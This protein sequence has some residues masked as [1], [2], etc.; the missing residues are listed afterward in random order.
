MKIKELFDYVDAV[1]PNAF[2]DEVKLVWLNE[3]EGAVQVQ[4]MLLSPADVVEY[5]VD[6]MDS[7]LLVDAPHSKIY[8][9]YIQAMIDLGNGE[10]DKYANSMEL[11]NRFWNEYS[12]WYALFIDPASGESELRGYYLSA[13][14]I[15]V[16]HGYEGTEEEWARVLIEAAGNAVSAAESASAAERSATVASSY[17]AAAAQSASNAALAAD[18]YPTVIGGIW[19]VWDVTTGGYVST[20]VDASGEDGTVWHSGTIVS[21][22]GTTTVPGASVGDFYLNVSTGQIFRLMATKVWVEE[23]RLGTGEGGVQA[24]LT[25]TDESS[26][27]FVR[28]KE[29]FISP[30]ATK[31]ELTAALGEYVDELDA[32]LGGGT[33]VV[34]RASFMDNVDVDYAFDAA[35]DANY[36]VIRI[37]RDKVDGGKQYPFVYA[38]FGTETGKYTTY[39]LATKEGWLLAINAGV[40]DT[41]DCTPDGMVIQ[42]GEVIKEGP[43]VTHSQCRPLL[44]D[45][46]GM[47]SSAEYDAD[48]SALAASGTVS[49]V[50]GFIPIIEDYEAVSP[51]SWNSVDH[52]T[53]NAQRQIFGQFGNGDYAVV[54]CEGRGHQASDG[55]TLAEAQEVCLRLGLRFAYNLDGGGSTET[56]L[57]LKHVNTIYEGSTGRRVPTFIVFN[58][59]TAFAPG[60]AEGGNEPDVEADPE[61][62]IPA[63]Y[64]VAEYVKTNGAQYVDTLIPETELFSVE[65]KV[66]SDLWN[67]QAGHVLSSK[68]T[69]MPFLKQLVSTNQSLVVKL[70]GD[71][72]TQ[73]TSTTV[74]VD[75]SAPFTVRGTLSDSAMKV[76]VDE[77]E[78]LDAPVGTLAEASATYHMFTYGGNAAA[79]QYRF[80]GRLYYLKLRRA[81]GTLA[82][83]FTPVKISSGYGL[84]ED[85]HGVLYTSAS[86]SFDGGI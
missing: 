26:S 86:G 64:Q 23:M 83:R 66:Q 81:D 52:Y 2:K 13:Y 54:T 21:E 8:A 63:E 33:R 69:Y 22:E 27:A 68:N 36:T 11:F 48:A 41:S 43:T 10:Y 80:S 77:R 3:I 37:Y 67:G 7:V 28:G 38:P 40:F 25:E 85:I 57:G 39:D 4:I 56:M 78:M 61:L 19:F 58:G 12:A 76:F 17:S 46:N 82:Y 5:G 53:Q 9:A 79:E 24:D 20:G 65:Y 14:A 18:R 16:K 74:N 60:G 84:Y 72:V 71:E 6:D 30:L 45:A 47:L 75:T 73:G 34:S 51:G 44:I 55:W 70:K 35:T 31:N 15:A 29:E 62:S 1:K 42:N 50:V 32:L 59:T 49:A